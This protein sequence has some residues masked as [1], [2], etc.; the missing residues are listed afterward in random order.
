MQKKSFEA[1]KIFN[2]FGNKGRKMNENL[3]LR[4]QP[5]FR[6]VITFV[7]GI[8]ISCSISGHISI[9][10]KSVLHLT[11]ALAFILICILKFKIAQ[12]YFELVLVMFIL[13]Y[14]FYLTQSQLVIAKDIPNT[15]CN[16]AVVDFV[17]NKGEGYVKLRVRMLGKAKGRDK[18]FAVSKAF[19]HYNF[20][21]PTKGEFDV[22]DRLVIYG[23]ATGVNNRGNPNEFNYKRYLLTQKIYY[24]YY[25]DGYNLENHGDCGDLKLLRRIGVLQS[26]IRKLVK[27]SKLSE[28]SKALVLALTI[29]QKKQLSPELKGSFANS[30]AMHVLAVSGLH[31]GVLFMILNIILGFLER[32]QRLKILKVILILMVIWLYSFVAGMSSSVTRASIMF[33]LINIGTIFRRDISIYNTLAVSAFL[34]LSINP[35]ELFNVGFQLSFLAVVGIVYFQ[36]KLYSLISVKNWFLDWGYKF[37]TVSIAAQISTAPIGVYYFNQFP[38]YFWLT[39]LLIVPLVFALVI[40]SFLFIA[41]EWVQWLNEFIGWILN[42]LSELTIMWVSLIDSIP[43]SVTKHLY[44]STPELFVIYVL[45]I[46]ISL[47]LVKV[48]KAYLVGALGL[49][50][51]LLTINTVASAQALSKRTLVVYNVKGLSAIGLYSGKDNHLFVEKPEEFESSYAERVVSNHW[52]KL[53]IQ[54]RT[55]LK[56]FDR[57]FPH[58]L[59]NKGRQSLDYFVR[60]KIN[61]NN[62]FFYKDAY[63]SVDAKILGN[64]DIVVVS[65]NSKPPKGKVGAKCLVLDGSVSYRLKERWGKY[66]DEHEL[67]L[68]PVGDKGAFIL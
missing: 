3:W 58:N 60:I 35:M 34:M 6:L 14:S 54:G 16:V 7:T 4:K 18:G 24:Q 22:G 27:S 44:L 63:Y 32:S 33:S 26:N 37:L 11:M 50:L 49:L 53:G 45:L 12:S 39:N 30:G 20:N 52:L 64:A 8:L 21:N 36:P 31:V 28:N 38:N 59:N 68:H 66:A 62:V 67:T 13:C 57:L 46:A 17:E 9:E 1:K 15:G 40:V 42:L 43:G 5:F 10:L 55:Q 2:T 48:K 65:G 61:N 29:G 41:T 56:D 25:V 23:K 47:W 51:I 19:V